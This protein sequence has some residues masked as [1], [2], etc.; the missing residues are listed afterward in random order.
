MPYQFYWKYIL[1][2]ILICLFP[3]SSI[4]QITPDRTL[5]LENSTVYSV[6]R[7][8]ER[9][10]GG[11]IRG[12]NL[13]H[14]FEEFNVGEGHQVYFANPEKVSN[15]FSRVTGNNISAIF[16]ILGVK[17]SAN[18]F[19]INP[20]GIIFGENATID[21][22]GSFIATTAESIEFEDQTTLV[23][24]NRSS[25]EPL[26]TWKAPIGLGLNN[27]SKDILVRGQGNELSF[28]LNPIT[29]QGIITGAGESSSGLK[30]QP[31]RNIALIGGN[32]FFD[33][34]IIT[35]PSG[36]IEIGSIKSGRVIFNLKNWDFN[37]S[38]VLSFDNIKLE[39]NAL[40]DASGLS[41]GSI[42]LQGSSIRLDNGATILIQ[43]QNN[44]GGQ[45]RINAVESLF[46][47]GKENATLSSDSNQQAF[48]D[49]ASIIGNNFS[50][51]GIDIEI[52]TR[53]LTIENGSGIAVNS[54]GSGNSGN[55]SIKATESIKV[56]G[57]SPSSP[58]LFPSSI[59]TL[60]SGESKSGNIII[61]AKNLS[62]EN[63]AI[64]FSDTTG[65]GSGNISLDISESILLRGTR[66]ILSGNS[67]TPSAVTTR[68]GAIS[69][70]NT[71][72]FEI[73][74]GDISIE[75]S[76]IEIFDG[77][78]ISTS[79]VGNGNGGNIS[80]N[81]SNSIRVAG[82]V[83]T[84][85]EGEQTI[86]PSLIASSILILDPILQEIFGLPSTSTGNAGKLEITTNNLFL[87]DTAQIIVRNDGIGNA[88]ELQIEANSIDLNSQG[89]IT[90]AALSGNGGN[91]KIESERI[92][93]QDSNITAFAEGKGNG[94][95]ITI[96][97]DT[98]LGIESDITATA[99]EGDGGNIKITA[100][101]LLGFKE[102]KAATN[103][104]TSDIDASSEFGQ[105]GTVT[106]V[107]PQN[108]FSDPII[109]LKE[110]QTPN[111]TE[112]VDQ[113]CGRGS[114]DRRNLKLIY[115]GRGGLEA[116]PDNFSDEEQYIP[117][118]NSAHPS[119]KITESSSSAWK[120]GDPIIQANAVRVD[121]NGDV[122]FVAELSPQ[123]AESLLCNIESGAKT[124]N[125]SSNKTSD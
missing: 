4:A 82:F 76:R 45:I 121:K 52:L 110:F 27:N 108:N 92:F 124:T 114:F 23:I 62:V 90:A 24:S 75:S 125:S 85:G 105:D 64:I 40:L 49:A 1:S 34:G 35:A 115:T 74:A 93:L 65:I 36:K 119:E 60:S 83:E 120:P 118:P 84:Q 8:R 25:E 78:A 99:F 31:N 29:F 55:I 87:E 57:A 73:S 7:L 56:S 54:F 116:T 38:E 95:N 113:N 46:L 10:E 96:N 50:S 2:S 16:G 71:D 19:L 15:I 117:A 94:G 79:S 77:G 58:L 30:V 102:R 98:I 9:I 88:G 3:I 6:D 106:F 53:N 89:Q 86:F 68:V 67:S 11:A 48:N 104:G 63:G 72:S 100:D 51:H 61:S 66:S 123:S 18:L 20:N 13:F 41:N 91:I 43:S 122:Y 103:N 111:S 42:T 12:E 70:V 112:E 21:V 69:S 22:G 28:A 26:L 109:A 97:A 107:N 32:V 101:G 80:I 37:Y 39:N 81:A 47:S 59:F 5:G 44:N 33:G 17:G 14:S